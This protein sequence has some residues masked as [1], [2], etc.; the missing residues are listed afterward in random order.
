MRLS[1]A[2]L[3]PAFASHD[4]ARMPRK[5]RMGRIAT[6]QNVSYVALLSY[7]SVRVQPGTGE[8]GILEGAH[9]RNLLPD[10][11]RFK[12]GPVDVTP[13]DD[14]GNPAAVPSTFHARDVSH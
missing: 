12:L 1:A 13:G 14:D 10:A 2:W 7:V 11:T 9:I 6:T 3:G 4:L 5:D 8:P